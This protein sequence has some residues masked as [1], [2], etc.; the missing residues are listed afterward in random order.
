M[1]KIIIISNKS[2]KIQNLIQEF[3]LRFDSEIWL[4]HLFVIGKIQNEIA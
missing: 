1:E 2:K 3:D 4:S